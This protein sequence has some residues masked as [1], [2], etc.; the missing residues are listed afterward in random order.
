MAMDNFLQQLRWALFKVC[1][2]CAVRWHNGLHRQNR[3]DRVLIFA[4]LGAAAFASI[5]LLVMAFAWMDLATRPTEKRNMMALEIAALQSQNIQVRAASLAQ[6]QQHAA[7]LQ[8]LHQLEDQSF[9][10]MR[11]WPN[12]ATRMPLLSQ[13]QQLAAHHGLR[14]LLLKSSLTPASNP[15]LIPSDKLAMAHSMG[16]E[17]TTLRIQLVGAEKATFHFWQSVHRILPNGLWKHLSWKLGPDGLYV[18]EAQ[19]QLWWEPQDA[20]TDT[21][22]EVHWP[23]APARVPSV[24]LDP[25][26][27]A[28]VFPN[29]SQAL[30]RVVG[31]GQSA[32][33]SSN[34]AQEFGAL[35]A[36]WAMVKS[37]NQIL[38]VQVGQLLGLEKFEVTR[39]DRQGLWLMQTDSGAQHLVAWELLKP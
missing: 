22:V 31:M 32:P 34:A 21:G 25:Q 23:K 14:V 8:V 29:H 13:L 12:S 5:H 1:P 16:Y 3:R 30:M 11:Y 33:A 15:P 18:F 27:M 6:H 38:P 37:G 26:K 20:D 17:S 24:S 36:A 35:P 2:A 39:T 19:L 9:E 7:S 28:H 10:L 4:L